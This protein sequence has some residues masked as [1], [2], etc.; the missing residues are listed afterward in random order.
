M[1]EAIKGRAVKVH[2]LQRTD[3]FNLFSSDPFCPFLE[4]TWCLTTFLLPSPFPRPFF[5]SGGG[6][7]SWEGKPLVSGDDGSSVA[8]FRSRCSPSPL[9][10]RLFS[11]LASGKR[12]DPLSCT[13][14]EAEAREKAF[15]LSE[16]LTRNT[17]TRTKKIKD[18]A[19]DN[20]E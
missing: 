1:E 8:S 3:P 14:T 17:Q 19:G 18:S 4:N 2:L 9:Q 6:R 12:G 20:A 10:A 15:P 11:L 13:C 7:E 16:S 5:L